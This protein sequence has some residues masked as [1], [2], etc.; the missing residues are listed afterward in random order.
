MFV[1]YALLRVI[2]PATWFAGRRRA[3]KLQKMERRLL[4]WKHPEY[5]SLRQPPERSKTIPAST[6]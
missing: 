5:I 3:L 6:C 1:V 4:D 2:F